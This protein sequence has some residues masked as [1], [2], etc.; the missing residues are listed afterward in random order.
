VKLERSK[1]HLSLMESRLTSM[2]ICTLQKI[3]RT[4]HVKPFGMP[5]HSSENDDMKLDNAFI[6]SSDMS[7]PNTA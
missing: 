7:C 2:N 4:V 3:A 6:A 5:N 1:G